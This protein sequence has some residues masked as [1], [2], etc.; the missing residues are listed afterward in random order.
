MR[1]TT[2]LERAG[3]PYAVVGG[4]AVALW[5]TTVD[6]AAV[7][8]TRDVDI[9]LRRSDLESAKTALEADGFVYRHSRGLDMFLDGPGAKARGVVHILM[10][11][12]TVRP[13]EGLTNPDVTESVV[14]GSLR[15]ITLEA[16]VRIKLAVFR[17][18]DQVH[19]QDLIEV[20][21]IDE[22]WCARFPAEL[23]SRLKY[24]IDTPEG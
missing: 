22:S 4:N 17:L 21:L 7:R 20:G 16:L 3:I 14:D 10:A 2:S 5:V 23:A 13:N 1:A 6:D 15:V 9:L 18:K 8:N 12:E 24:I 11:G 19:L